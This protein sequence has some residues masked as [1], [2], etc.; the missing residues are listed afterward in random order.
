MLKRLALVACMTLMMVSDSL[1]RSQFFFGDAED[2]N[3]AAVDGSEFVFARLLYGSG[4]AN[5]GFRGRGNT[6][7][8]D[9]PE[10]DAHFMLGVDRLSNIRIV[11]D[12]FV[13][14]P[15]MDPDLFNYPLLYA[16]EV[17]YM[18]LTQQEAD[19]LREYM[20][21][22]GFMIV[23]DF[24]GTREWASFN[25][26]LQKIFPDREVED[27]PLTHEIFH[28]F[29]DIDEVLQV[30][31][32]TSGCRGGPTWEQD[33]YTPYAFAIFDDDRRPMLMIN[34]NTDLGDAWEWADLPCYPHEYSGYA[35]RLGLNFIVYSMTH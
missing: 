30:P 32:Y 23:D 24:W 8:T 34:H 6:W 19:R 5:F 28:S 31:V 3:T 14:V 15:I 21:R 10:A 29:Y 17:G 18:E 26:Q 13:T 25:R 9:W 16:V 4:L 35:Y 11:L 27:V 7:S 1:P 2:G 20:E 33:G 22:G 12:D